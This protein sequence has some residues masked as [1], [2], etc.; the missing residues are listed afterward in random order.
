MSAR[1]L[2]ADRRSATLQFPCRQN[3]L[4]KAAPPF[5][6]PNTASPDEFIAECQRFG[7]RFMVMRNGE[8]FDL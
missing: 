8:G 4:G 3:L 5:G 7:Q 6:F 2:A 1:L